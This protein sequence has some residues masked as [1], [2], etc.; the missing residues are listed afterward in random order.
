MP[1]GMTKTRPFGAASCLFLSAALSLAP[2]ADAAPWH[3]FGPRAMGMG[4][5]GVALAQGPEAVYWNPAGLG[6]LYNAD[7]FSA[8][9]GL[10]FERSGSALRGANDLFQLNLACNASSS[11]CTAAAVSQALDDLSRYGDGALADVAGGVAVQVGKI[12]YF[13]LSESY[14][15]ATPRAD[16]VH[17]CPGAGCLANNASALVLRGGSFTEFGAGYG[18]ELKETG[19]IVGANL[20]GIVGKVGFSELRIVSQEP[21]GGRLDR[22]K[23]N[24]RVS[25]MPAVDLGLLWDLRETWPDL[26]ARPRV[27]LT[28]R[29]V[30]CPTFAQPA[31]ARSAGE[32]DRFALQGQA[33]LGAALSPTDSW[34]LAGDLDLTENNTEVDG[35]T[36]RVLALGTEVDLF[37]R[38]EFNLP[39]RFGLK[40]NL[41]ESASG[42]TLTAGVGL[43]F[44][45]VLFDVAGQLSPKSLDERTLGESRRSAT[46]AG[47]AFRFAMLYGG[48]E[49]GGRGAPKRRAAD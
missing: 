18:L 26:R 49:E 32:T 31:A 30:N 44:L 35:L 12:A 41:A 6:Q 13:A 43:N 48:E 39:L 27:G 28:G 3:D 29:N 8:P 45:H 42:L 7:G 9:I 15:G 1:A 10:R 47:A 23:D 25:F 33:R 40:K 21:G 17:A 34:H 14:V 24:A 4:G 16:R 2:T 37:N 19:L 5:A 38:P 22:F 11:L 36:S 46:N 20:K